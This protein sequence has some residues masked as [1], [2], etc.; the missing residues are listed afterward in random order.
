MEKNRGA[1]ANP[2]E[3]LDELQG[4]LWSTDMLPPCVA[5]RVPHRLRTITKPI[6]SISDLRDN[7]ADLARLARSLR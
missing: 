2:G 3:L 4:A 1:R 5:N 7:L 6:S